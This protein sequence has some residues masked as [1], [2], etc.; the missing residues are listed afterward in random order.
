MFPLIT[1]QIKAPQTVKWQLATPTALF[2]PP[3]GQ[4]EFFQN[5]WRL[6]TPMVLIPPSSG[7]I[8]HKQAHVLKWLQ[9]HFWDLC[10]KWDSFAKQNKEQ[11]KKKWKQLK[12]STFGEFERLF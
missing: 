11:N 3:S 1:Q 4:V 5:N 10:R 2:A 6:A 8:L 7:Q 12:K 9:Q